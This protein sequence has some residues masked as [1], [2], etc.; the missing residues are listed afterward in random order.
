[1]EQI[2]AYVN[3]YGLSVFTIAS[4]II[5]FIGFLKLCKVFTKIENNKQIKKFVYYLLNV[6]LA[7]GG[8]AI[9]FATFKLSWSE[10]VFFS[11]AQV[12]AT[13]TLYA[14]YENLGARKLVQII[15]SNI[16][17]WIKKNPERKTAKALKNLGLTEEMLNK[18]QAI[19]I[20]ENNK[21]A[22][23]VVTSNTVTSTAV[24]NRNTR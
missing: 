14:I 7:F 19:A 9:Y 10:Y 11:C 13:T 2:L 8:A 22:A 4:C 20:E 12:T 23:P 21:D 6:A 18:L 3:Q 5:V 1:M 17:E 16:A 24:Y 15:I